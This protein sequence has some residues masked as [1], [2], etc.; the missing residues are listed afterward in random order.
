[1]IYILILVIK[2][3][4][5]GAFTVFF[6]CYKT[7]SY[8]ISWN[9]KPFVS[10]CFNKRRLL[11]NY[12]C[13]FSFSIQSPPLCLCLCVRLTSSTL[14]TPLLCD[15]RCQ[16]GRNLGIWSCRGAVT[17]ATQTPTHFPTH[18]RWFMFH[19]LPPCFFPPLSFSQFQIQLLF[20]TKNVIQSHWGGTRFCEDLHPGLNWV[21]LTRFST[22]RFLERAVGAPALRCNINVDFGRNA[23]TK[24]FSS[25]EP[26]AERGSSVSVRRQSWLSQLALKIKMIYLMVICNSL[27]PPQERPEMSWVLMSVLS[28]LN[29]A[30]SNKKSGQLT[31]NKKIKKTELLKH[32]AEK[33]NQTAWQKCYKVWGQE[34][35]AKAKRLLLCVSFSVIWPQKLWL[36][37]R[38]GR[39]Y[40]ILG[41]CSS[42]APTHVSPLCWQPICRCPRCQRSRLCSHSEEHTRKNIGSE[43]LVLNTEKFESAI[44]LQYR[45]AIVW[46]DVLACS[47]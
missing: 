41:L 36:E 37:F 35:R 47:H 22:L 24:C 20:E 44:F 38:L 2:E 1:M 26:T 32:E 39:L 33:S 8:R 30:K 40:N 21:T 42:T 10:H 16:R 28:R 25:D 46:S 23:E 14:P 9:C 27:A 7:L 31:S 3:T 11:I 19:S 13:Q 34:K 45:Q 15:Q 12:Q 17:M 18:C 43:I 29:Q 4:L 6:F 5:V